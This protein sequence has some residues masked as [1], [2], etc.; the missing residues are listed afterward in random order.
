MSIVNNLD[1]VSIIQNLVLTPMLVRSFCLIFKFHFLKVVR[2]LTMSFFFLYQ[3]ATVNTKVLLIL[4]SSF[5][6]YVPFLKACYN[7]K[8]GVPLAG[9]EDATPVQF[10][11]YHTMRDILDVAA[12]PQVPDWVLLLIESIPL[13]H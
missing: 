12:N 6:Y 1:A 4:L 13:L 3:D 11:G 10:V 2:N 5:T 7:Q 9:D 8:F